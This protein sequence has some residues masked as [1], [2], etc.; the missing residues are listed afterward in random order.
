M[1]EEN[2]KCMQNFNH[3]NT[4]ARDHLRDP[5]VYGMIILKQIL[6]KWGV[7]WIQGRTQ[8]R[9]FVN[10]VLNHRVP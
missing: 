8:W 7:E 1:N 6:E 4:K 3:K 10:T 5:G 9:A 2:C